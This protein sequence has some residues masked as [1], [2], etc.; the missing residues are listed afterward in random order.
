MPYTAPAIILASPRKPA[1]TKADKVPWHGVY[2]AEI[3]ERICEEVAMGRSL[4]RIC[5]EEPWAPTHRQA[6]YWLQEN[7]EFRAA[8]ED[9]RHL[10]ASFMAEQTIEIADDKTLDPDLRRA[11]VS[12][13]Q[14]LTGKLA[15]KT[16]GDRKI[17]DQTVNA[18]VNTTT[19]TVIDVSHLSLDEIHAAERAFTRVIEGE[20]DE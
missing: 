13:R 4:E 10:R 14:W 7:P 17:V 20:L 19:T 2:A 9:S 15:P 18:Q 12:A 3:A 16:F 8:Y 1:I 5:L 6:F 11:M